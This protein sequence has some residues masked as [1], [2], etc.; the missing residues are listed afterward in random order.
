MTPQ[1][2]PVELADGQDPF[3]VVFRARRLEDGF[4]ARRLTLRGQLSSDEPDD[5]ME[6]ED[7][8][9]DRVQQRQQ[10]VAPPRVLPFVLEHGVELRR[11]ELALDARR[12]DDRVTPESDHARLDSTLAHV[13]GAEERNAAKTAGRL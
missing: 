5:R 6:P 8:L 13:R 10:V 1:R 2:I 7:D 9:D 3:G 4:V 12:K 11:R